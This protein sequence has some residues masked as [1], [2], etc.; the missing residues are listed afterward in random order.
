MDGFRYGRLL[1]GL[2]VTERLG[3]LAKNSSTDFKP[4]PYQQLAAV[5]GD[6]G[7]RGDRAAVL[8]E[9]EKRIR[10]DQRRRVGPV[11]QA[12]S[13]AWQGV[14]WLIGHG[15]YP[16]R[17]AWTG[18]LLIALTGWAMSCVW[19]A[20]DMT[21]TAAPVLVSAEWKA[22]AACED[23]RPGVD[24]AAHDGPGRDYE[25]FKPWLYAFDVVVPLIN[26]GQEAAWGPSTSRS[27]LGRWAHWGLPLV[28]VMGWL[29][30]ALAASAVTGAIRRD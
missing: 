30:T 10:A 8:Y 5:Y 15:Y 23:C 11:G 16:W 1:Q 7:H 18:A 4:Q 17:A 9:M 26:V 14:T 22:L 20:G 28:K 27:W 12:V 24:W 19:W 2:G 29:I 3:W 21:P 25:T 6:L 13:W